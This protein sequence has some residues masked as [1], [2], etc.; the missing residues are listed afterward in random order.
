MY[1][2]FTSSIC[3][4]LVCLDESNPI[5]SWMK[6]S[7]RMIL[8]SSSHEPHLCPSIKHT[9]SIVC[10]TSLGGLRSALTSSSCVFLMPD[11]ASR[12]DSSAG[13]ASANSCCTS[14]VRAAIS[15][16]CVSSCTENCCWES[17]SFSASCCLSS[18]KLSLPLAEWFF[19]LSFTSVLAKEPCRSATELCVSASRSS[20]TCKCLC[21]SSKSS[22]F[23]RTIPT[24]L[25]IKSKKSRGETW[26]RVALRF[27]RRSVALRTKRCM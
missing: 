5:T 24:N 9:A 4:A 12:A 25:R 16:S 14:S 8:R 20:P 27:A 26:C 11:T 19:S 22:R 10:C 7:W 23:S 3:L 15:L 6:P 1:F 21:C 17:F 13:S 2:R 18:I